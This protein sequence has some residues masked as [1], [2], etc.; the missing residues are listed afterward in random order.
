M[1]INTEFLKLSYLKNDVLVKIDDMK[2]KLN[3]VCGK[4]AVDGNYNLMLDSECE[5]GKIE[6][7]FICSW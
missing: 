5:Y 3:L 7:C 1:L 2:E 4:F 6:N